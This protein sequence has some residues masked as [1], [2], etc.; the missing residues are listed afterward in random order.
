MKCK[1]LKSLKNVTTFNSGWVCS[2]LLPSLCH[3]SLPI[4]PSIHPSL[5][6]SYPF[7]LSLHTHTPLSSPSLRT[8]IHQSYT[9]TPPSLLPFRPLFPLLP[10]SRQLP[11]STCRELISHSPIFVWASYLTWYSNTLYP[12]FMTLT[13]T[14]HPF[15]P[16]VSTGSL[17]LCSRCLIRHS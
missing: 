1:V 15:M 16:L 13:P 9:S 11:S 14:R 12:W 17:F 3:N 4:P 6:P 10:S 7:P 5:I 8:V 2:V